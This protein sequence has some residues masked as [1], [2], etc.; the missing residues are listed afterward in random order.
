MAVGTNKLQ[1]V[2]ENDKTKQ[3][4]I[5]TEQPKGRREAE[6]EPDN[7]NTQ[8]QAQCPAL[9][10]RANCLCFTRKSSHES[11]ENLAWPCQSSCSSLS[12]RRSPGKNLSFARQPWSSSSMSYRSQN[13]AREI[14]RGR[15]IFVGDV[16][17]EP[18]A[19]SERGGATTGG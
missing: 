12:T 2:V 5:G 7:Q 8:D 17:V 13:S 6:S 19:V 1:K 15:A 18:G 9:T 14:T 16:G 10:S 11:F 4:R 3:S